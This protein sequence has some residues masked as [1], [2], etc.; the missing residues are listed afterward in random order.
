M[1]ENP[2]KRRAAPRWA[3]LLLGLFILALPGAAAGQKDPA[4]APSGSPEASILLLFDSSGSMRVDDGS[5]KSR[6]DR[7]K[8]AITGL[9]DGSPAGA[10]IGLRVIGGRIPDSDKRR[11]CQ[12]SRIVF[13]IGRLDPDAAKRSLESYKP[14]GFTPIA[15]SLRR[16]AQ[17]LGSEGRRTII[18]VSD[19]QETCGPPEPCD[20]AK[21]VAKQG[22]ELKI[23]TIGFQVGSKSRRQLQCIAKAGGGVYRDV[24]DAPRLTQELRA[25]SVRALRDYQARGRPVQGGPEPRRA[26]EVGP[27]Q[28]VDRIRADEE[29]WFAVRLG[30]R[31]T[32]QAASTLVP[33]DRFKKDAV[34][35]DFSLQIVNDRFEEVDANNAGASTSSVFR[36]DTEG[37]VDSIGVSGRPVG[38]ADQTSNPADEQD[39]GRPGLYYVRLKLEDNTSKDLFNKIG[40]EG[41]PFELLVNVLGRKGGQAPPPSQAGADPGQPTASAGG[42]EGGGGTSGLVVALVAGGTLAV[43]L[44]AGAAFAARKRRPA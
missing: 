41:V 13:P 21:Q 24:Q 11:G 16:A 19:G 23:Q 22:V 40:P 8:E 30:E 42:D 20:I 36:S 12:D 10:R 35:A 4:P 9:I 26:T 27:G 14:L 43:G 17:D 5:G 3:A 25:L 15:L 39:F 7:A 18:L 31:E 1:S 37:G 29:R 28:Y 33:A 6:I 34:G 2:D 38:V 32:V 44:G